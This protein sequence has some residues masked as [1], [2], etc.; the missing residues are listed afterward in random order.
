MN[1]LKMLLEASLVTPV[2]TPPARVEDTNSIPGLEDPT[3]FGATKPMCHHYRACGLESGSHSFWV[4]C[5]GITES[6][7]RK[8]E[9]HNKR[10]HD[11]EKPEHHN[12]RAT[13]TQHN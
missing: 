3:C 4:L 6:E 11:N 1:S 5:V 12:L 8:P 7:H 9:L 13:S 2:K 10:S